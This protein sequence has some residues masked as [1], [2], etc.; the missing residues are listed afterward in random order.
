MQLSSEQAAAVGSQWPQQPYVGVCSP[1]RQRAMQ[2]KR[3]ERRGVMHA[4]A[5]PPLDRGSRPEG[6]WRLILCIMSGDLVWHIHVLH[7]GYTSG[8]WQ[9]LRLMLG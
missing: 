3:S 1:Q 7:S 9:A 4:G 6:S 5:R 8:W 2:H